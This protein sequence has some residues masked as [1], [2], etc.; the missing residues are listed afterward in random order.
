MLHG[1]DCGLETV[2]VASASG[3]ARCDVGTGTKHDDCAASLS[4]L[5]KGPGLCDDGPAGVALPS[6]L[7]AI[8]PRDRV[9]VRAAA[10]RRRLRRRPAA[11][12][13]CRALAAR[14]HAGRVQRL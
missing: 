12:L 4:T 10:R 5:W 7:R 9:H 2:A 11:P 3:Y 13:R 14:L 8:S 1:S 6:E